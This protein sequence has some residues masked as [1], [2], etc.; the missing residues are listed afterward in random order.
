MYITVGY[1]NGSPTSVMLFDSWWYMHELGVAG[2]IPSRFT[3][4]IFASKEMH[5]KPRPGRDGWSG[6]G[7]GPSALSSYSIADF[8]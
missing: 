3:S 8:V 6:L 5:M 4:V 7:H 2:S 1:Y